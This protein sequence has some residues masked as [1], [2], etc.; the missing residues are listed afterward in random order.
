METSTLINYFLYHPVLSKLW[1]R[2]LIRDTDSHSEYRCTCDLISGNY[3]LLV[4]GKNRLRGDFLTVG[5][6]SGQIWMSIPINDIR[7]ID[8]KHNIL[9][10]YPDQITHKSINSI[11]LNILL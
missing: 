5:F 10:I 3:I 2:E 7:K 11:M 9:G 6:N 4:C 1:K 8:F